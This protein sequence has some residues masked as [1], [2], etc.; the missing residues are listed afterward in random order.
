[1]SEQLS[2][3][4]LDTAHLVVSIAFILFALVWGLI[5]I[6]FRIFDYSV[7]TSSRV[8][9]STK[10]AYNDA[11][12][13]I[14]TVS[15]FVLGLATLSMIAYISRRFDDVW[16][17]A[18]L[19]WSVLVLCV[20]GCIICVILAMNVDK[21][22]KV[23]HTKLPSGMVILSFLSFIIPSITAAY[24]LLISSKSSSLDKKE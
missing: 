3:E 5:E 19:H 11:T 6:Q 2:L 10:N 7:L 12:W 17:Y 13:W 14:W 1:M 18:L 16:W 22:Q 15:T 24:I 8:E 4:A 23:L 21:I 20:C 9:T